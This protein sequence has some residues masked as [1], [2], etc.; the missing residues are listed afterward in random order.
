MSEL[1]DKGCPVTEDAVKQMTDRIVSHFGEAELLV[2]AG[3]VPPGVSTDI[4]KILLEKARVLLFPSFW[5]LPVR[6]FLMG[7]RADL[8]SSSRILTSFP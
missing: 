1:N 2:L 5:M 3:S 4:Y 8:G 7:L 6:F